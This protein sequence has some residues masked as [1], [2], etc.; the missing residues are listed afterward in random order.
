MCLIW[1]REFWGS[2]HTFGQ[3]A[4]SLLTS[5]ESAEE[6]LKK[7]ACFGSLSILFFLVTR[8]KKAIVGAPFY[9]Q[10]VVK[11]I[12]LWGAL[13]TALG[14]AAAGIS[15]GAVACNLLVWGM[16]M[17]YFHSTSHSSRSQEGAVENLLAPSQFIDYGL[18]WGPGECNSP[19][20]ATSILL[21]PAFSMVDAFKSLHV[22][23]LITFGVNRFFRGVTGCFSSHDLAVA[24]QMIERIIDPDEQRMRDIM[25]EGYQKMLAVDDNAPDAIE[26]CCRSFADALDT[27]SHFL[28]DQKDPTTGDYKPEYK[29]WHGGHPRCHGNLRST[30][31]MKE[32]GDSTFSATDITG[33]MQRNDLD[34]IT[35]GEYIRMMARWLTTQAATYRTGY[36]QELQASEREEGPLDIGSLKSFLGDLF[37]SHWCRANHH[38]DVIPVRFFEDYLFRSYIAKLAALDLCSQIGRDS[39]GVMEVVVMDAKGRLKIWPVKMACVK[40]MAENYRSVRAI[41]GHP[42]KNRD[43][44]FAWYERDPHD[45]KEPTANCFFALDN[46]AH[47][48]KYQGRARDEFLSVYPTAEV[49]TPPVL[50]REALYDP[51]TETPELQEFYDLIYKGVDN[52]P[53]GSRLRVYAD[54]SQALI[55]YENGQYKKCDPYDARYVSDGAVALMV[56]GTNLHQNIAAMLRGGK[57]PF[58]NIAGGIHPQI[59]GKLRQGIVPH[60]RGGTFADP[61]LSPAWYHIYPAEYIGVSDGDQMEYAIA[62]LDRYFRTKAR[63]LRLMFRR[64]RVEKIRFSRDAKPH[65]FDMLEKRTDSYLT[66]RPVLSWMMLKVTTREPDGQQKVLYCPLNETKES[67]RTFDGELWRGIVQGGEVIPQR[68]EVNGQLYLHLPYDAQVLNDPAYGKVFDNANLPLGNRDSINRIEAPPEMQRYAGKIERIEIDRGQY[69]RAGGPY[70]VHMFLWARRNQ[71]GFVTNQMRDLKL[72]DRVAE[73]LIIGTENHLNEEETNAMEQQWGTQA[74]RDVAW[75]DHEGLVHMQLSQEEYEALFPWLP[76]Y[77]GKRMPNYDAAREEFTIDLPHFMHLCHHAYWEF[78]YDTFMPADELKGFY[79]Q[80]EDTPLHLR[81]LHRKNAAAGAALPSQP[82]GRRDAPRSIASRLSHLKAFNE[83]FPSV[84]ALA[85]AKIRTPHKGT[86]TLFEA[87]ESYSAS[88]GLGSQTATALN[89][90]IGLLET[91]ERISEAKDDEAAAKLFSGRGRDVNLVSD[92]IVELYRLYQGL[93]DAERRTLWIGAL[94]HDMGKATGNRENHYAAGLELFE[95]NPSIAAA[96][97]QIFSPAMNE[98]QIAEA[99]KSIKQIILRHDFISSFGILL[100]KDF[101][102]AFE[103]LNPR[104]LAMLALVSFADVDAQGRVGFLTPEKVRIFWDTYNRIQNRLTAERG[105][106]SRADTEW[107]GEKRFYAWARGEAQECTDEEIRTALEREIPAVQAR[108]NFFHA[109]GRIGSFDGIFNLATLVNDPGAM[110]KILQRVAAVTTQTGGTPTIALQGAFRTLP[111]KIISAAAAHRLDQSIGIEPGQ[112]GT[113]KLSFKELTP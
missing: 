15:S 56:P 28:D 59:L 113:I 43:D 111:G 60:P 104:Q 10:P 37:N 33:Q 99:I 55:V 48:R 14:A 109:L 18:T 6:V 57:D 70:P 108:N 19:S 54:G 45:L 80:G 29:K 62:T 67:E 90:S 13:G 87:L 74:I 27:T 41:E 42:N 77:H 22:M 105:A 84:D 61:Y 25:Y 68:D 112:A 85:S 3:H 103:G 4:F 24:R 66:S 75:T 26:Q 49:K 40:D 2:T 7:A 89:H 94:L 31:G 23:S 95:S 11:G 88:I 53:G 81:D 72:P 83:L 100:E 32:V 5:G 64:R 36:V 16:T 101:A 65:R 82:A 1:A 39:I 51:L 47:F 46:R 98:G 44:R 17:L 110:I 93:S 92:I 96:I 34:M 76:D 73:M 35:H 102:K 52:R 9:R 38:S 21:K 71:E 97:R 58:Q 78:T 106:P 8:A 20:S 86:S 91:L 79:L 69:G 12:L 30:S 63:Y 50:K 107:W